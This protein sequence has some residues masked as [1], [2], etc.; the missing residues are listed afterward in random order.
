MRRLVGA[1]GT[2]ALDARVRSIL[3]TILRIGSVI[4][5]VATGLVTVNA[6]PA[7]AAPSWSIVSSPSPAGPTHG[8]LDGLAC[9]SNTNCQAVGNNYGGLTL[10]ERW[11]G[12]SWS[13]VRTPDPTWIYGEATSYLS[14]IACIKAHAATALGE[15]AGERF[16]GRG[17][18]GA[19]CSQQGERGAARNGQIEITNHYDRPVSNA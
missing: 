13:Q 3:A 5:I 7:A 2:A 16:D 6:T 15:Q 8:E 12:T 11:N 18:A 19:V 9:T 14:D 10:G 4:A 17:L 1:V